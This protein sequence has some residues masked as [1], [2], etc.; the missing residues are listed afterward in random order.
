MDGILA[1][2]RPEEVADAL[3]FVE[4]WEKAGNMSPEER[5][6]AAADWGVGKVKGQMVL[7]HRRI[8]ALAGPLVSVVGFRG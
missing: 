2:L 5:G 1:L 8:H 6:V 4:V 7:D 3:R